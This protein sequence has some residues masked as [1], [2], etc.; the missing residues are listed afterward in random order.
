MISLVAGLWLRVTSTGVRK[1]H[2]FDSAEG[3][4]SRGEVDINVGA[5]SCV[6]PT[7]KALMSPG[8]MVLGAGL[9]TFCD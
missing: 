6:L 3:L 9:I 8:D 7:N 5:G 4:E 2:K 1:K